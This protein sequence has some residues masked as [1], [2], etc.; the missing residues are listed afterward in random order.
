[1]STK[2]TKSVK[3]QR[4]KEVKKPVTN[5]MGG[6]SY[7]LNPF[8]TMKMV[9]ASSIFGE[10]QY[11]RNGEFDSAKVTDGTYRVNALVKEY[12]IESLVSFD[13]K[14]TSEI[15]E[16]V[17]DASLKYDYENTLLYAVTLRKDFLMRLNP[18]I[19]MV[20]AA[21]M[22]EER[23]KYTEKNP[24][25]FNDIN[26]Q[27]MSRADDVVS[28]VTYYMFKNGSKKNI[29]NI[30]KRSWA[31]K[32]KSLTPYEVAK[33]KDK[34]IGLID[35]VRI[36]HANNDT[37]NELMKTGTVAVADNQKTWERLRSAENKTWS[38]ILDTIKMPHMALLRNL[39]GIFSEISD[40]AKAD[41]IL[42]NLVN[43]VERGKQFPYRYLSAFNAVNSFTDI[44][45]GVKGKVLDSL[46]DC[47]DK[48]CENLPK[49]KGKNVFLSDNSGSAWGACPSEY[50]TMTVAKIDNL[51][52]VI[53]AANSD[54]GTVVKFGDRY[55]EFP[56]RKRKG[57]LDQAEEISKN[58]D[59]SVGGSTEGG[60]WKFLSHAID[61]KIVYDNIF[62]YSDM[63]AG[64]GGLYGEYS[65]KKEY[66]EKGFA[67]KGS[68]IDVA[69]VI[70][71]Y[72]QHVN[73]KVNVYCVQTAGYTNVL[74]PENGYR[75]NVLYGWTGKELVY[76]KAMNDFWDEYDVKKANKS[77]N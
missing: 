3:E 52:S 12:L 77:N 47:M 23:K 21:M 42:A 68:Y 19:I 36:C 46:E 65:D 38:E 32:V 61:E 50:G 59:N 64:H 28:Q 6:T 48:A 67:A 49:L 53:G 22:T 11:Y 1:M 31:N 27:V 66:M 20:R 40:M 4:E 51:S 7:E 26:M 62:I 72:R 44:D 75:T 56:T 58:K 74:L 29:P 33:Y 39:R 5:F 9:T 69:K 30:L 45:S 37:I 35:T 63:Q 76:A 16:E 34:G 24:G 13:N 73:P 17:I 14:K 8:E 2:M 10:P 57:I 25:R 71:Y 43:G 60:I 41:E 55:E 54:D 15:M 18:Q 70:D